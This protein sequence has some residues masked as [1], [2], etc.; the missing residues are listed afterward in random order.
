MVRFPRR[1]SIEM[2]TKSN[3][4]KTGI[5]PTVVPIPRPQSKGSGP[6]FGGLDTMEVRVNGRSALRTDN[7]HRSWRIP[8]SD[9]ALTGMDTLTVQFLSPVRMGQEALDR[10]PWPIPASNEA[11]PIGTQTSAVTRK[12][13]YHYG[14]DWGPRLVTSGLWKPVRWSHRPGDADVPMC[15]RVGGFGACRGPGA[16]GCGR[17]RDPGG[18]EPERRRRSVS[19]GFSR[20]TG[21]PIGDSPPRTLVAGGNGW[22][23]CTNI[24]PTQRALSGLAIRGADPGVGPGRGCL[25]TG[26]ALRDKWDSGPSAWGECDSPGLFPGPRG[27]EV[28]AG[29]GECG[30]RPH[31]HAARVGRGPL[32][33]RGLVGPLR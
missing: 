7:M 4:W 29:G 20:C 23:A 8:A 5:G 25:R 2:R 18:V 31:E 3:G 1:F 16:M 28:V 6:E 17:E 9:L 19:M 22:A 12:A 14:W 13:M 11:K 27:T 24:S 15:G 26:H 30:V 33:R 32:C 21:L 10:S